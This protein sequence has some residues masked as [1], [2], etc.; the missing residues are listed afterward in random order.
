MKKA[1]ISVVADEGEESPSSDS[2]VEP[3]ETD[4]QSTVSGRN[5]NDG[6]EK[7]LESQTSKAERLDGY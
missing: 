5:N 2:P 3:M 4:E 6:S 7:T 1:K